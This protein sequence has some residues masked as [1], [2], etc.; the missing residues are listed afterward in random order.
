MLE[1]RVKKCGGSWRGKR[2]Q[3]RRLFLKVGAMV[4]CLSEPTAGTGRPQ[5]R[6]Y[7]GRCRETKEH[8]LTAWRKVILI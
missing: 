2:V 5:E 7:T 1:R 4:A 6:P 3:D 8:G